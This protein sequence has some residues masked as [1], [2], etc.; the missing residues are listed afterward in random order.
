MHYQS[1]EYL[2]RELAD[3]IAKSGTASKIIVPENRGDVYI[4]AGGKIK[5]T[6]HSKSFYYPL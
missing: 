3:E 4:Y 5:D 1:S 6:A 2:F